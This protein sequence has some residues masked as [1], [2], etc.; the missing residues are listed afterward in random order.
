MKNTLI[1]FVLIIAVSAQPAFAARSG[2]SRQHNADTSKVRVTETRRSENSECKK[3]FP[4]IGSLVTVP[5]P[6]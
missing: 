5:C 6:K 4:L 1:A 2:S 3:Y